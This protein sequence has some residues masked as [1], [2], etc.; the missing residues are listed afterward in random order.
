LYGLGGFQGGGGGYVEAI[1]APVHA[2]I[3]TKRTFEVRPIM[4]QSEPAVPSVVDVQPS[5]QPVQVIFRTQSSPVLVQQVHTP[6]APAHVEKTNSEDEPHRVLHQVV[7]PVIQ[8][9][10]EIIQRKY[11]LPHLHSNLL[12]TVLLSDLCPHYYH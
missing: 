8:E 7:R 2:A 1:G 5:E 10:R 4:L 12:I 9:V 3:A 11:S 6:S